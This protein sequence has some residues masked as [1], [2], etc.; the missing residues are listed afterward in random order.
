MVDEI[1][2]D[3]RPEEPPITVLTSA[4][5]FSLVRSDDLSRENISTVFARVEDVLVHGSEREKDA[6]ATGLLEAVVSAIDEN[7]ERAWVLT[8][9]GTHA[10]GYIRAWN[11]FTLGTD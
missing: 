2:E 1:V 3:W 6:V 10:T 9:A 8:E 7:P 4:L 5:G 11:R